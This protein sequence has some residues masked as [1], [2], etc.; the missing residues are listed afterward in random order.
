M[1]LA[2]TSMASGNQKLLRQ[3]W[4]RWLSSPQQPSSAGTELRG[5]VERFGFTASIRRRRVR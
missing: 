1:V 4:G 5:D 2:G 3:Q